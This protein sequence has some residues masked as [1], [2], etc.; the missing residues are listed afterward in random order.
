[1]HQI[2]IL[3]VLPWMFLYM[4]PRVQEWAFLSGENLEM[5]LPDSV[6]RVMYNSPRC[7]Q[8]TLQSACANLDS[9]QQYKRNTPHP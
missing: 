8:I 5:E 3:T 4:S 7:W 2:F 1:M 9:L 6:K